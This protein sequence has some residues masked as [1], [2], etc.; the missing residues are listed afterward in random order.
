MPEMGPYTSWSL[1]PGEQEF[2]TI[3]SDGL[4]YT[5][6]LDELTGGAYSLAGRAIVNNATG[7]FAG[8]VSPNFES[9]F[10]DQGDGS[11][12]F[13]NM[14]SL[15]GVST[16][17]KQTV[18]NAVNI[19]TTYIAPDGTEIDISIPYASIN[20]V[21]KQLTI[22]DTDSNNISYRWTDVGTEALSPG[23]RYA[24]NEEAA[25]YGITSA[26]LRNYRTLVTQIADEGMEDEN[27]DP[28]ETITDAA[29]YLASIF[30]AEG[31][32]AHIFQF[33][34]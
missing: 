8:S 24:T 31:Q 5:A 34:K 29:S 13:V 17:G 19:E 11:F 26:L 23:Y 7:K 27:G 21:G 25:N 20:R 15:S 22:N 1:Q 12:L 32:Y 18:I 6:T 2:T 28:I 33:T 4:T 14:T 10:I 3:S 16:Y 30:E 9:Q